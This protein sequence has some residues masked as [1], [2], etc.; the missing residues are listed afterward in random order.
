MQSKTLSR[1]SNLLN[2][3]ARNNYNYRSA[4]MPKIATPPAGPV[5]KDAVLL[6]RDASESESP[7]KLLFQPESELQPDGDDGEEVQP[8]EDED[9]TPVDDTAVSLT[10]TPETAGGSRGTENESD[11][12]NESNPILNESDEI[13]S[14]SFANEVM[15]DQL[16]VDEADE[17]SDEEVLDEGDE[18]N[19]N[20]ADDGVLDDNDVYDPISDP[21]F[22]VIASDPD[23]AST[24]LLPG[25]KE[26][27]ER[28]KLV[29]RK[30][31]L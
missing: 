28:Q 24:P 6:V 30:E 14:D 18:G 20:E 11:E 21:E 12:A 29:E 25:E 19:E 8:D 22:E 4:T 16:A 10:Q 17:T 1:L 27:L 23:L 9:G 26:E 7:K 3:I 13:I 5:D 15:S 31:E 2:N